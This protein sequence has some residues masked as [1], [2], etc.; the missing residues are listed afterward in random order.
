MKALLLSTSIAALLLST[1]AFAS[2][3]G[4]DKYKHGKHDQS[5]AYQ[6]HGYQERGHNPHDRDRHDNGLHRGQYKHAWKRGEHIPRAYMADR[7]Y[8]NDYRTYRL[9]PPPRGYRWVRPY[10]DS[11]EYLLIQVTTGIISQIFGN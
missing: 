4:H 1:T 3:H 2:P 7:Y 9:A 8:I 5:H 6:G 10:Q 11:N